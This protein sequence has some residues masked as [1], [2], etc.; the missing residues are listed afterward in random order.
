MKGRSPFSGCGFFLSFVRATIMGAFLL[1]L[2]GL[3]CKYVCVKQECPH[4]R[5][6]SSKTLVKRSDKPINMVFAKDER[7]PQ[8]QYV[9]IATFTAYKH[10]PLPH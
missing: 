2:R 5:L 10:A 7:G 8:F 1:F 4:L 3:V 9:G 6:Q